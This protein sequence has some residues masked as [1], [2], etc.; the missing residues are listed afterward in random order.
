LQNFTGTMGEDQITLVAAQLQRGEGGGFE[1]SG[2]NSTIE[3]HD[4]RPEPS[5]AIGKIVEALGPSGR[6]D[7]RGRFADAPGQR[8]RYELTIATR[9]GGLNALIGKH[10]LEVSNVRGEAMV[11][12]Q[13]VTVRRLL[14][15]SHDGALAATG[16]V[17]LDASPIRWGGDLSLQQMDVNKL[18]QTY[19]SS[20][21]KPAP[22]ANGRLDGSLSLRGE[23]GSLQALSGNGEM[24]ITD[25]QLWEVPVFKGIVSRM[26]LAREALTAG[27]AAAVFEIENAKVKL[28][29]GALNSP[30][31]GLEAEGTITFSG[32]LDL[33]VM[34][35]P[36]GDWDR[37]LRRTGI[38][39]VSDLAGSFAG[40][41]QRVV[42]TA[43][44][45]LLFEFKV[46]GNAADPDINAVP[47][48]ILTDAGAQL[49]GKM[50]HKEDNLLDAI[51]EKKQ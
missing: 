21:E 41:V 38:P 37:H 31:L 35:A 32:D 50:M 49:L 39:L 12:P 17:A 10:R 7:V 15:N 22:A 47:A 14:G 24:R 9:G 45:Q 3:F 30:A 2:I 11:T 1:V 42:T 27:E 4:P 48:P 5:G 19:L 44:S 28:T 26:K 25:G 20:P 40:A 29:K 6:Y 33:D 36:L 8:A 46:K 18:A 23:A 34:A 13:R 51:K 43:T 16:T